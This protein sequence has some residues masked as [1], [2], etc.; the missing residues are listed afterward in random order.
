MHCKLTPNAIFFSIPFILTQILYIFLS[1]ISLFFPENIYLP[2]SVLPLSLGVKGK[3]LEMGKWI[4]DSL[5]WKPRGL[6]EVVSELQ[7][8]R[9]H[10]DCKGSEDPNP[11]SGQ[12]LPK[13][14]LK[15]DSHNTNISTMTELTVLWGRVYPGRAKGEHFTWKIDMWR[16]WRNSLWVFALVIT[17]SSTTLSAM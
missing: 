6:T 4:S 17:L 11:P 13:D 15:K 1:F 16:C 12:P 10:R 14:H 3:T 8:G 7:V 9:E 5:P 2:V